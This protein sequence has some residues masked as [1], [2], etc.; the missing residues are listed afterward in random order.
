MEVLA[1]LEGYATALAAQSVGAEDLARPQ[2]L[3]QAMQRAMEQFDLDERILAA[4]LRR[5]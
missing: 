4:N 3:A 2:D 5:R 1:I